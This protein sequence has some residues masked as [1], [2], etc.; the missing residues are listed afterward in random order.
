[1]KGYIFSRLIQNKDAILATSELADGPK[2]RPS[3]CEIFTYGR[4]GSSNTE[5]SAKC[6]RI[7]I[8]LTDGYRKEQV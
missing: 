6:G 2:S 4:T 7:I 1:V 5:R 8:P 3:V